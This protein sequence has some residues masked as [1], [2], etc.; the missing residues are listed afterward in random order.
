[1]LCGAEIMHKGRAREF[2]AGIV[3]YKLSKNA[4]AAYNC[5]HEHMRPYLAPLFKLLYVSLAG[6][7]EEVCINM[8]AG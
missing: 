7:P 6:N 5:V 8:N 1:M 4:S 2:S 3:V